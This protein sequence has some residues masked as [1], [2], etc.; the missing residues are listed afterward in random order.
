MPPL[1]NADDPVVY[2]PLHPLAKSKKVRD[3][4]L[5]FAGRICGDSKAPKDGACSDVRREYSGNTR[6][7]VRPVCGS[8]VGGFGDGVGR[9]RPWRKDASWS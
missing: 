9:W 2:T 3:R 1:L 6:Q 7:Q 4:L 5:F 8:G